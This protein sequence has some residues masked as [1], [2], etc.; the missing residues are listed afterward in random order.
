MEHALPR[1]RRAVRD[2]ERRA[3]A[4]FLRHSTRDA[5]HAGHIRRGQY[6]ENAGSALR[7]ADVDTAN[8]GESMGR[9][10]KAGIGL[11]W[12]P[13]IGGEPAAAAQQRLILDAA[14]PSPPIGGVL[15]A[16][17]PRLETRPAAG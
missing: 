12:I 8:P 6:G 9:P 7:L 2:L 16:L 11:V 14:A 4:S 10:D 5:A 3:V 1:Q 15:F 17:V 13:R